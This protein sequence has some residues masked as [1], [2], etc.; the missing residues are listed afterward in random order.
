MSGY[1]LGVGTWPPL[2]IPFPP[3]NAPGSRP[4]SYMCSRVVGQMTERQ[5]AERTYGRM[6]FDREDI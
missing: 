6:S 4:L 2:P 5:M 3:S 1:L